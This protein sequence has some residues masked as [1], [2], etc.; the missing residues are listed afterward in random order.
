MEINQ[1]LKEVL[2]VGVAPLQNKEE[3]KKPQKN[4]KKRK[5]KFSFFN[6]F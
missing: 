4:K 2:N 1:H 3:Q 6:L 5:S